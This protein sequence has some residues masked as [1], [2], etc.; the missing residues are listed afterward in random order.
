MKLQ[1]P[2]KTIYIEHADGSYEMDYSE[3][4]HVT[5]HTRAGKNGK[6][7]Y[8]PHCANRV[9]VYHFSWDA[10]VCGKCKRDNKSNPIATDADC[11][12]PKSDWLLQAPDWSITLYNI[13]SMLIE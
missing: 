1:F 10:L 7:L 5:R 9:H 3:Y 2:P 11:E 13:N 6:D 8:C 12:I 4:L